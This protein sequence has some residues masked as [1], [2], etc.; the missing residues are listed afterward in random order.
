[1]REARKGLVTDA[2]LPIMEKIKDGLNRFLNTAEQGLLID[3]DLQAFA[4]LLD[5]MAQQVTSLAQAWWLTGNERRVAMGKQPIDDEIMDEVLLP[6]GYIPMSDYS[7]DEYSQ[8]DT[9]DEVE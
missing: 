9:T 2:V 5:D 4:E 3:Y 8:I 6:S 7:L 1:M